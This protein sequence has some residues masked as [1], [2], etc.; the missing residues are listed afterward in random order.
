MAHP[1]QIGI[2]NDALDHLVGEL[3]EHGLNAIECYYPKHSPEQESFYLRLIKKYGLH[4]TG[5]SDFHGEKVKPDVKMAKL[6]L[7]LDWLLKI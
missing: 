1:Y 3:V 5:G 6:A 4:I 7:E 2:D